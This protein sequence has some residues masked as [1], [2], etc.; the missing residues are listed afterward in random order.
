MSITLNAIAASHRR[1]IFLPSDI[2]N[3]EYWYDASRIT[4]ISDGAVVGTWNDVSGNDRHVSSTADAR[5][6]LKKNILAGRQVVRFDGTDDYLQA[7]GFSISQPTH[8]FCVLISN[9]AENSQCSVSSGA[10]ATRQLFGSRAADNPD[11]YQLFST[12]SA[13]GGTF[14]KGEYFVATYL[15]SGASSQIWKNGSSVVSG[16][17]PGVTAN[18]GITV[19]T[20]YN[21]AAFLNGDIAELGCYSKALSTDE[22]NSIT[23]YL[24]AKYSITV[25]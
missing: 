15:F 25:S 14:P 9:N 17:N 6:I 16:S 22:R 20:N 2:S 23:A 3:L 13:N 10:T 11:S 5:P 8:Y 18:E 1:D 12:A 7:T 24:G 21:L 4:G 19:G